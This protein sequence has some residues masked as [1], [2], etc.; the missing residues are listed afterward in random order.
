[1]VASDGRM[2]VTVTPYSNLNRL[3]VIRDAWENEPPMTVYTYKT[4][5]NVRYR[6]NHHRPVHVLLQTLCLIR[7][8]QTS[9]A[10]FAVV[11]H[12]P[13]IEPK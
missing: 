9:V 1:V 8:E 10:A 5:D 3:L 2:R 4:V 12:S 11:D 6:P 13:Y 7:S